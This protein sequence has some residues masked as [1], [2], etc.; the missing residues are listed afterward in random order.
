M[1]FFYRKGKVRSI[2][3][4]TSKIQR[5]K[6]SGEKDVAISL[7]F[8]KENIKLLEG[9]MNDEDLRDLL[10]ITYIKLEWSKSSLECSSQTE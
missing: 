6:N 4:L 8:P 1:I 7:T 5:Q 9:I 3:I 10:D 2:S